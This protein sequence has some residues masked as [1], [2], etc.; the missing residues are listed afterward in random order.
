MWFSSPGE[1][2]AVHKS[3]HF[4]AGKKGK[5][6]WKGGKRESK[7]MREGTGENTLEINFWLW[8]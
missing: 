7:K 5:K 4:K 8:P 6:R 3:C 1:L 2:T